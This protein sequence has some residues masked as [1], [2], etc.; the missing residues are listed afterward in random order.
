MRA[1]IRTTMGIVSFIIAFIFFLSAIYGITVYLWIWGFFIALIGLYFLRE[2]FFFKNIE[3][4]YSMDSVLDELKDAGKRFSSEEKYQ[5]LLESIELAK[6]TVQR[7]CIKYAAEGASERSLN[8]L[9]KT[10]VNEMKEI[11]KE[12]ENPDFDT[13]RLN[14]ISNEILHIA[15]RIH[16]SVFR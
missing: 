4:F 7:A 16:T 8:P 15:K 14:D 3:L 10:L 13:V 5:L 11:K 12:F 1:D 6:N 2:A 9:L